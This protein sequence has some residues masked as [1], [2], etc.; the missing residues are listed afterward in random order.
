MK[1]L[2][3]PSLSCIVWANLSFSASTNAVRCRRNR[4]RLPVRS[5]TPPN[6][7]PNKT[8]LGFALVQS[9]ALSL[10]ALLLAD[11]G[12]PPGTLF[13][14]DVILQAMNCSCILC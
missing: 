14:T 9:S 1:L 8:L 2:S 7:V 5:T 3:N 12:D 11:S 10:G 6:E 13:C 4:P